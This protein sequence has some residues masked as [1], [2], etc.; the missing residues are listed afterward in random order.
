MQERTS[1]LMAS[2]Q[3][4]AEKEIVGNLGSLAESISS[5]FAYGGELASPENVKLV[6]RTN[7][8]G[9]FQEIVFPKA[10]EDNV[11]QL[12]DVC[13]IASFGLDDQQVTDT[14]YRNAL[15]LDPEDFVSSFQV[16]DTPVLLE[17][18]MTM[19][20]DVQ[21]IR[22]EL[23]K[24]NIYS[25]G[26]FFKAHVDTPRS[27]KMFGSL[28]VCLPTQFLGGAL[29][30]RHRD[31][32]IKFE[33]SSPCD[34]PRKTV[35]WAVF[36]SDVEHEVLPVT[37]GHR[38]TLTYNLY[39]MSLSASY[40]TPVHNVAI[41]P[42]YRELRAALGNPTF[43][44]KGAVLGFRSHH[45][46]A[47]EDLN[48]TT[49]LPILLKGADRMVYSVARYLGLSVF[50]KPIIETSSFMSWCLLSKFTPFKSNSNH[51]E[52]DE[53]TTMEELF[54]VDVH[55]AKYITWCQDINKSDKEPAGAAL[56]YGNEYSLSVYYK[57]VA[58]LVGIPKWGEY[59]RSCASGETES[60][61]LK[62]QQSAEAC[63]DD[64]ND[65]ATILKKLCYHDS[66]DDDSDDDSND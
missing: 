27:N 37:E 53:A 66:D 1:L 41:N 15:K 24:L 21:C 3:E 16:A 58:I 25:K 50:V 34:D 18:A 62:Q 52:E 32:E 2:L 44:R 63:V 61:Q 12:I 30:T 13:L 56:C 38:I 11:K 49:N 45:L 48:E 36:F 4:L 19:V 6:Y 46:Y 47:Y 65:S 43:M 22:A 8:K 26:G 14:S 64:E 59:R 20:P 33:W 9:I 39:S 60:H 29:V 51:S 40:R 35:S 5:R 42:L 31:H 10:S 28:V 54:E 23:Y 55:V 57:T 17:T 7:S